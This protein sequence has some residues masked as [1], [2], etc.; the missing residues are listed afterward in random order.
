MRR[1]DR[2]TRECAERA[3]A[4]VVFS[5]LAVLLPALPA[6]AATFTVNSLLDASDAN[7]ADNLCSTSGG[8]CTLRAALQQANVTPGTDSIAFSV[9]GTIAP[10]SSLPSITQPLTIDG[11]TAPGF[12]GTP[13]I[14]LNG[15]SA[16]TAVN[17]LTLAAGSG[18]STVRAL[19]VQNFSA[20]GMLVSSDANTFT[21]DLLGT[22]AAGSA[23]A[24]NGGYGIVIT[25]NNN[26]LGGANYAERNLVSGNVAGGIYVL[27][28]TGNVLQFSYVGTNYAG[29]AAIP[30][31]GDGVIFDH[32]SGDTLRQDV[33]SGNAAAGVHI[34]AGGSHSIVTN[35]LIG[36]NAAGTG[37]IPNGSHGV[38]V[39]DSASNVIGSPSNGNIIS[40]NGGSGVTIVGSSATGNLVQANFIG[41]RLSGLQGLA[42]GGNGVWLSGASG[43]KVGNVGSGYGNLISGNQVAGVLISSGSGNSVLSNLIG[44][45]RDASFAIPNLGNGVDVVDSP[46]NTIGITAVD[47]SSNLISG[48]GGAGVSVQGIASTGTTIAGNVIGANFNGMTP[49]PNAGHGITLLNVSNATIGGLVSGQDNEVSGNA[50]DGLHILGGANN[51]ILNNAFGM[52]GDGIVAVPNAGAGIVVDNSAG[53]TIRTALVSANAGSGIR[54]VGGSGALLIANIVGVNL[55]GDPAGNGGAG[56]SIEGSANNTVGRPVSGEGNLISGNAG[57][58]LSITGPSATGNLLQNTIIGLDV[59]ATTPRPNG[60]YGVYIAGSSGNTIGGSVLNASNVIVYNI[61]G[62]VAVLSGSSNRIRLNRIYSNAGLGIDLDRDGALP[63][64][65]VTYNDAGDGD[66]GAN[67]LQNFP[68]LTAATNSTVNGVLRGAASTSYTVDLFSASSCDPAGF[69]QGA[70]FQSTSAVTTNANGVASFAL[71]VAGVGASTVFAATATSPAGNTSEFSQCITVDRVPVETLTLFNAGQGFVTLIG[72]SRD[73]PPFSA[74]TS[75]AAGAPV[76]GQWVMGDWNGDGIETPAVYGD[77]GAFFYTNVLGQSASWTGVWFGL[78]NRQPVAGR[79]DAA[80]NHDCLG[81][82]DSA[83]S[84]PYGTAF[85][86]YFTC[87]LTS[88]GDPPKETQWLGAP[89]SDSAGFSG[90]HQF[91]AGDLD[92]DGVDS[93]AVRRGPYVAWTNV[94]PT[95]FLS[96]FDQA[97]YLGAPNAGSGQLVCGDWDGNGLDSFGLFYQDGSLFRRDDLAWNSGAYTLQRVGQ[98]NGQPVSASSWR[99][100]GSAGNP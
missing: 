73:L 76:S 35:T 43:N 45:S 19:A 80:V 34:I 32:A 57:S 91:A 90:T 55:A 77:N 26:T 84:P 82:V 36:L 1:S 98:P 39:S 17:G 24:G 49:L 69:G 56:I 97:Q 7:T 11:S 94:P 88:S 71:P 30:N 65:G 86:L 63:F 79:F 64:D 50:M 28:G 96:S 89:L 40:G 48:N 18:G 95:T 25:G 67:A 14:V 27:G 3:S 38:L 23:G 42:N 9:S 10:G 31:T 13:I 68:V 53:T 75:Y 33:L 87:D 61:A 20:H 99:P 66:A 21:R 16:G 12:P 2:S 41:T 6:S 15:G 8:V 92:G 54:L 60:G 51:S 52:Q 72:S 74:Y 100:G 78:L 70:A 81:V 93:L 22:N 5:L 85:A 58:G 47:G 59:A 62:G 46:N 29:T 37:A 83:P 4:A 44:T